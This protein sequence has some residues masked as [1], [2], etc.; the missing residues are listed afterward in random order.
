MVPGHMNETHAPSTTNLLPAT[1]GGCGFNTSFRISS[2]TSNTTSQS[3]HI[4]V[5]NMTHPKMATKNPLI[6]PVPEE[7]PLARAPLAKVVCAVNFPAILKIVDASGTGIAGFQ[8]AIRRDYPVLNQEIEHAFTFQLDDKG[9]FAPQATASTVWR[10]LDTDQVWRV[11]LGRESL[12]LETQTGYTSRTE[13]LERF[14]GLARSFCE[15]LEPAQCIRVGAR[16]VNVLA[17]ETLA[18]L[19]DYVRPEFRAFGHQPFLD[20]L[21]GGNQAAEFNVPEGRVIVRA[22]ILK[23]GQ[24]HDPQVLLP[25]NAV[26]Y[27]LDLDGINTDP[28]KFSAGEIRATAASLTERVYT[29]FRWAVTDKLLEACNG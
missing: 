8:E 3:L 4:G 28:R 17:D 9:S 13:F 12:A 26:R 5:F 20:A 22:G 16:Y 25:N 29:V 6:D 21:I 2:D 11:S 27:F 7:V 18:H 24:T 23:A 19:E 10:F 15:A 1:Q 14:E